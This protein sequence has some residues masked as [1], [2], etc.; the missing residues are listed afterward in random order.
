MILNQIILL[1]KLRP[2]LTIVIKIIII[3]EDIFKALVENQLLLF[4]EAII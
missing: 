3:Y 2:N 1:G 4:I